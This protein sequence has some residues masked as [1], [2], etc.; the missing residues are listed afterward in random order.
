M[1]IVNLYL[2][3]CL[4]SWGISLVIGLVAMFVPPI[5]RKI[6]DWTYKWSYTVCNETIKSACKYFGGEPKEEKKEEE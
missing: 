5:R 4:I 3:I 2:T 6:I 1:E